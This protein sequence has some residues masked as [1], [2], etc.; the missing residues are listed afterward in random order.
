M[1]RLEAGG[2]V[3]ESC[4]EANSLSQYP[5]PHFKCP[6]FFLSCIFPDAAVVSTGKPT[7]TEFVP[8]STFYFEA[9]TELKTFVA[10]RRRWN[11]GTCDPSAD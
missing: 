10:Q 11:N 7:I 2:R 5:P 9:E 6:Y 3:E 8:E 1:S 4:S